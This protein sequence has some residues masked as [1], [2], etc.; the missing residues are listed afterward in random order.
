MVYLVIQDESEGLADNLRE[1]A[2]LATHLLH[3]STS[4]VDQ[5]RPEHALLQEAGLSDEFLDEEEEVAGADF[6]GAA[7]EEQFGGMANEREGFVVVVSHEQFDISEHFLGGA[8]EFVEREVFSGEDVPAL[9]D[10][11]GEEGGDELAVVLRILLLVVL[12]LVYLQL[13]CHLCAH[14]ARSH[15]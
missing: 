6:V 3:F 11:I 8:L 2:Q 10:E 5:S 7:L 1:E 13:V 14:F 15:K 12:H 4:V 9:A